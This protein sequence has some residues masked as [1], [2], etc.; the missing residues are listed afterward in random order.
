MKLDLFDLFEK[1]KHFCREDLSYEGILTHISKAVI[2]VAYFSRPG[3]TNKSRTHT[4]KLVASKLQ[5]NEIF[6][7]KFDICKN[8]EFAN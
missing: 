1:V 6:G 8:S 2:L 3:N 7:I 5:T 4:K